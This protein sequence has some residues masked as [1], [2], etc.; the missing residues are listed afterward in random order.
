MAIIEFPGIARPKIH[1]LAFVD[2]TALVIGEVEIRERA[3]IWMYTIVR[4]DDAPITIGKEST[5]LEQ[6]LI[7]TAGTGVVIGENALVNHCAVV[8][9]AKIEN[10][11]LVGIRA[12]VSK[13]ARI[14]EG[15]VVSDGAFVPP[16]MEV[17]PYKLISGIPAKVLRDLSDE[18]IKANKNWFHDL[19]EKAM[20]YKQIRK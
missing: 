5:I 16:N 3:C 19:T 9:G 11:A 4:A 15:A 8:H 2:P 1:D 12:V 14:G 20:I 10:G 7:E 13:G 17:P 18:E 6:C